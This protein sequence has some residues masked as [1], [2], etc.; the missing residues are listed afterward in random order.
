[1][2]KPAFLG[3]G[4]V[5][6]LRL[7]A[8]HGVRA[9]MH[10]LYAGRVIVRHV[11]AAVVAAVVLFEEWGWRP[12]ADLLG[13][14]ARLAPIAALEAR[15]RTLPPYGA[16]AVFALPSALILPLK[17]VALY[18]VAQGHTVFAGL[19]FVGAKI[20]GT[21]L[22][23]RIYMLTEHALMQIGWFKRGYDTLM[24]LKHALVEWARDSAAWKY[25]RLIKS[26]VKRVLAPTMITVRAQIARLLARVRGVA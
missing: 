12:L 21:A 15:L 10:L 17:L 2:I 4:V 18:L 26:R 8:G 13:K 24:P 23:A 7:A 3:S 9:L 1:M 19:L 11:I 25:G 16:L 22:V 5:A 14:L 20:V 6:H